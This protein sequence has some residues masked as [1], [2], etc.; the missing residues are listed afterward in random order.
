MFP[1]TGWTS[2][3]DAESVS[4]GGRGVS[5]MRGGADSKGRARLVCSVRSDICG[6]LEF[7]IKKIRIYD[8]LRIFF[9][10]VR[11]RAAAQAVVL[12]HF[13]ASKGGAVSENPGVCRGWG[14]V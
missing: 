5:G 12:P 9:L 11:Q 3:V 14:G 10:P 4:G 6:C 2:S 13:Y 8:Y 7:S 1:V